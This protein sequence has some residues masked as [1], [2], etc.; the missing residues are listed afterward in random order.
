MVQYLTE[1]RKANV[2]HKNKVRYFSVQQVSIV[3]AS[4]WIVHILVRYGE[5]GECKVIY[6]SACVGR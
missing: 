5:K 3:V 4:V 6:N 1:E 2:Y